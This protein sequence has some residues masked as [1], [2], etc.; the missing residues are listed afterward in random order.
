MYTIV[1][2]SLSNA[3]YCLL[4]ICVTNAD[5]WTQ[6]HSQ[7]RPSKYYSLKKQ[8]VSFIWAV[9][10]SIVP[11][12]LL[13]TPSNWR[14]LR[15]SISKFIQMRRFEKFSLN[16]CMHK[17]KIS[18]FPL[19]SDKYYS[20]SNGLRSTNGRFTDMYKEC[21]GLDAFD[22]VKHEILECW[23]IWFFSCLVVP[24][25]QAHF[26]VTET[27]HEN[28]EIF[29]Y[30]KSIWKE[31][32]VEAMT[33]LKDQ[34][35]L[36]LNVA[37]AHKILKNRSFGFSRVRF[38]PKKDGLRILQN[39]QASSRMPV[40]LSSQSC[41]QRKVS[42]LRNVK[43]DDFRSVNCALRD[44]HAVLKGIQTKEPE[45][46]GSSVFNYNDVYNKLV[47]F[48]LILKNGSATAPDIFIVVSDVAKAF[49]SIN[50]DKLLTM[51]KDFMSDNEYSLAKTFQVVCTKK[52]LWVNQHLALAHD[53]FTS[54]LA[55]RPLHGILV[56]QVS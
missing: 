27:E 32:K 50:Q 1:I 25:V 14:I 15:K 48:L 21:G 10:R 13:G 5:Y 41:G 9:C 19:L 49:D 39:L 44:L 40:K 55:A 26:Y 4:H 24:L 31:V 38:R 33:C 12:D 8:V 18:R 2:C 29:Y 34:Q 6:V 22:I 53:S 23:M 30:R 17:V 3:F 51:T 36:E 7:L 45:K 28:Q 42:L 35:F 16:Q 43:Y 52:S 47:P 11:P 20:N 54:S 56:K 46:L 37:S